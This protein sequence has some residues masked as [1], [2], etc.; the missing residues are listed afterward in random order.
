M[1]D[2]EGAT[3]YYEHVSKGSRVSK[4]VEIA[5]EKLVRAH[6]NMEFPPD[7]WLG[8][9][10]MKCDWCDYKEHCSFWTVTD[11]YLDEII[12]DDEK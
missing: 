3:I 2:G 12:G 10:M 7:P 1:A 8:K 4:S 9:N 6:I 11:E 5:L